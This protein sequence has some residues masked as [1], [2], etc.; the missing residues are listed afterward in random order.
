MEP[1][2]SAPLTQVA[3]LDPPPCHPTAP[4]RPPPPPF[5]LLLLSPNS[6]LD[7][8]V[9]CRYVVAFVTKIR[10]NQDNKR[11]FCPSSFP[12]SVG[13]NSMELI[14]DQTQQFE[15]STQMEFWPNKVPLS[16]Q[17]LVKN[18]DR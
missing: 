15:G 5:P 18:P 16:P 14:L 6:L 4:Q 13:T 2:I 7:H 3:L 9:M 1:N 17:T 10:S 8:P 11:Y 12:H